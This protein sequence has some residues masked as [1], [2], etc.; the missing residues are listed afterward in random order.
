[1]KRKLKKALEKI[2]GFPMSPFKRHFTSISKQLAHN[3]SADAIAQK[4]LALSYKTRLLD[5]KPLPPFNEAGFKISS[6]TDEDG[7][8]LFLFSVIGAKTKT[9]V[10]I[11]AGD[12]IECNSANLIINHGWHALLFDGCSDHVTCG[13]AFYAANRSTCFYPPK[14]VNAWITTENVNQ[15]IEDGGMKGE[16]DLLSLDMDGVDYWILRE[17]TVIQPRVI[18]VEYQDILGPVRSVTVPYSD[19]FNGW[20]GPTTNGMPN[21]CGASLAAFRKL[22]RERGY[23][24]VGCNQYG[25]NAFFVRED[26]ICEAIPEYR[27]EDCFTH[28]KVL[29]GMKERFPSVADHPWVEV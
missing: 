26:L 19:D 8:L 24:L 11:C 9:A 28:P 29:W 21:F 14:F 3:A 20:A 22:L 16:I 10:E 18:V 1:M 15:L 7:L 27:I 5:G 12:G 23:R 13:K 6:Q 17:I 25:F 4:Q 2:A